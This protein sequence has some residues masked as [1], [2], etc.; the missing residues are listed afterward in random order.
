MLTT[1]QQSLTQ[2]I[3]LLRLSYKNYMKPMPVIKTTSA[4]TSILLI[5][6][7]DIHINPGPLHKDQC[8][9]CKLEDKKNSVTC[10]TCRQW[11]HLQCTS[12]TGDLTHFLEK[13][14]Q[15]IC[16]NPTCKP[17]HHSGEEINPHLSS[18]SYSMLQEQTED[19]LDP[20]KVKI[21][22][23][24]KER[25]QTRKKCTRSQRLNTLVTTSNRDE[26]QENLMTVLTRITSKDYI[27]K[28]RKCD[29]KQ[30]KV[31]VKKNKKN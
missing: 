9:S 7:G 17:N 16:P 3:N 24:K 22:K 1:Q 11:T 20:G 25:C 31:T 4:F 29:K 27:G 12:T 28:E 26:S 30:E 10:E 14:F 6:A 13:S 2:L 8:M 23:R 18:N 19:N 15:W 5:L 21:K